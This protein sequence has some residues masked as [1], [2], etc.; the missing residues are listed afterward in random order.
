MKA[1][2]RLNT[3]SKEAVKRV[4]YPQVTEKYVDTLIGQTVMLKSIPNEIKRAKKLFKIGKK[5]KIE[6]PVNGFI[7]SLMS[8]HIKAKDNKIYNVQF[9][10]WELMPN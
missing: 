8:V 5:Y 10:C 1:T 3:K 7:N 6:K 2:K 9:P 4:K